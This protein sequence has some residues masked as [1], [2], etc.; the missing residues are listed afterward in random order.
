MNN[1][2]L[3]KCGVTLHLSISQPRDKIAGMPVIYFVES[4]ETN[5]RYARDLVSSMCSTIISDLSSNLY[6]VA[7]LNFSSPLSKYIVLYVCDW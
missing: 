4:T 7:Y 5:V 2:E 6:D 3:R 1:Y